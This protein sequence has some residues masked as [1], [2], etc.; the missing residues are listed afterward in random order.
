MIQDYFVLAF[1]N[2]KHRGVRSWLTLL[3]IF[4]GVTAVVALISLGNGLKLAVSNQFG[5]S[6]TEILTV[7]A[8]GVS[9]YGPPGSYVSTPLTIK[10]IESIKELSSVK[11]VAR[12]NIGTGKIEYKEIVDFAYIASIPNEDGRSLVY[13]QMNA[14]PLIGRLLK[15]DD[16]GKIFLG[17]N[18]YAEKEKWAGGII[19][20]KKIL[21][22]GKI[23][24]VEGVLEKKGSFI[25]DNAIFMNENE[26][27]DLF[28]F[29]DK[30]DI[31]IVQ[32]IDKK[33][34]DKTKEDIEKILRKKR[35]VKLGEEDFSVSTPEANME[36]VNNILGGVQAFIVL[37]ASVSIFIG[38]IGIVNTMTTSVLERIRE[39]GIM[40]SIGA[41]NMQIFWQFFIESGLLGLTGGIAG[42]VFGTLLGIA[43]VAGLNNFLGVNVKVTFSFFL[44]GFSLIGS[45]IVGGIA[46]ILPAMNAAKQNP[47]KALRS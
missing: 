32:P 8:G 12:R 39:I 14:K 27:K 9:G 3:G 24:E 26:M 33:E 7:E 23:F 38:A 31:I 20:G 37:V 16:T 43:G 19:P 34:I 13:E 4:I 15:K 45:F 47:V 25:L 2:L 46:G 29:G 5:V 17:Y 28:G 1:K 36:T 42:I 18:Y 44:V 22:N 6:Q 40:K 10:D 30:V 35:N 41:T 21:I 11:D